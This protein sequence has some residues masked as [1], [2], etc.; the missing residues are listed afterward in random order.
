MTSFIADIQDDAP[1]KIRC[2]SAC[3][4]HHE[5]R[6]ALPQVSRTVLNCEGFDGITGGESVSETRAH[7]SREGSNNQSLF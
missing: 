1:D 6:Q 2:E 5:H 4:Q 7:D 3:K